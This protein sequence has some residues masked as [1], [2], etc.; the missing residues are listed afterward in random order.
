[1]IQSAASAASPEGFSSRDQVSLIGI[2]AL[3][4]RHAKVLSFQNSENIKNVGGSLPRAPVIEIKQTR[5]EATYADLGKPKE[6]RLWL[7]WGQSSFVGRCQ[8]FRTIRCPCNVVGSATWSRSL[9][10]WRN[11]PN[12]VRFQSQSGT[13]NSKFAELA[14][15]LAAKKAKLSSCDQVPIPCREAALAAFGLQTPPGRLH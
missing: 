8:T 4:V 10:L 11:L 5:L 6:C 7:C 12:Y 3:R 13:R 15:A 1:M 9:L 14:D 2:F